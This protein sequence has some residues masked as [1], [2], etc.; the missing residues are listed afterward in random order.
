MMSAEKKAELLRLAT[1]RELGLLLMSVERLGSEWAHHMPAEAAKEAS[2]HAKFDPN[3]WENLCMKYKDYRVDTV[4]DLAHV[5]MMLERIVSTLEA[6]GRPRDLSLTKRRD[7]GGIDGAW[8]A[9]HRQGD[10]SSD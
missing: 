7:F 6:E 5:K 9:D 4:G 10:T 1:V 8:E 2:I 3:L